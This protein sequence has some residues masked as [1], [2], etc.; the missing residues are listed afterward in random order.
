MLLTIATLPDFYGKFQ[1]LGCI[2]FKDHMK[3]H[4]HWNFTIV[5]QNNQRASGVGPNCGYSHIYIAISKEP[6]FPKPIQVFAGNIFYMIK[7]VVGLWVFIRPGTDVAIKRIVKSLC[8]KNV[9]A[10]QI[11]TCK[12]FVIRRIC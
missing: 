1:V 5:F 6:S 10:K 3:F 12:W 7:K 8:P 2:I 4:K 11:K 9:F